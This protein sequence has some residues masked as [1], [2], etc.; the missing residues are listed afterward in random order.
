MEHSKDQDLHKDGQVKQEKISGRLSTIESQLTAKLDGKPKE[1]PSQDNSADDKIGSHSIWSGF[2]QKPLKERYNQVFLM[3][4]L[5]KVQLMKLYPN[6]NVELLKNGGLKEVVADLM[7]E[8]CIGTVS[9][10]MGLGY[11]DMLTK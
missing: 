7:V 3:P 6:I 9:L 5:I 2:H 11:F 4:F 8:N 1:I 10:P